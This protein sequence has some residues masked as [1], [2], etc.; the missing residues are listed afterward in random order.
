M[1]ARAR[2]YTLYEGIR[3]FSVVEIDR[4]IVA[5]GS[6]HILWCDL[7]EIRALAVDPA[8]IRRGFGT[9]LVKHS[10]PKPES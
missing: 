1:L 4:Q 3:E 7:A 2:A 8:Y 5:V 6:L 9:A 10:W